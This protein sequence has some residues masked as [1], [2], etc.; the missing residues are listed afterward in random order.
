MEIWVSIW[1]LKGI[2]AY[3]IGG[4]SKTRK[5]LP[6]SVFHNSDSNYQL[7]FDRGFIHM[8]FGFSQISYSRLVVLPSPI[9]SVSVTWFKLRNKIKNA[10]QSFIPDRS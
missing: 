3:D 1:T 5:L 4:H 7:G 6:Q 9:I 8:N 2:V 10:S